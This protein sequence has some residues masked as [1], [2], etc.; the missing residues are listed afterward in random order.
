M[1]MRHLTDEEMDQWLAD[2]AL[3]PALADHGLTCIACRLRRETLLAA[4][5]RASGVDPDEATRERIRNAALAGWAAGRRR[6]VWRRWALAAAAVILLALVP[7]LRRHGPA[8]AP[9]NPDVVL[10]E[11]DR[12]LDRDPL[13]SVAPAELVAEIAP[14]NGESQ[15]RSL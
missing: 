13:A 2:G 6:V 4:V 5:E 1:N 12:V 9:L 3:P 10:A 14:R 7:V 11:V 8:P 15:E